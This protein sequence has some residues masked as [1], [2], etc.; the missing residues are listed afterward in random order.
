MAS[1]GTGGGFRALGGALVLVSVL[2]GLGLLVSRLKLGA[3]GAEGQVLSE[4]HALAREGLAIPVEGSEVPLIGGKVR[5]GVTTV[6]VEE[7]GERAIAVALLDFT[8]RLGSTEVSSLGY[9]RV[10]FVRR[11]GG[12]EPEQGPAPRL[13]ASVAALEA[14]RRA[15]EAGDVAALT[16]MQGADG[17]PPSAVPEMQQLLGL[18]RRRYEARSW[19]LRSERHE[20]LVAEHFRLTGD[21]R[22]APVDR[23][24]LR[25]L[26]LV[27]E[28]GKLTFSPRVM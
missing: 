2:V 21:A 14:R 3:G 8:G 23:L 20:V 4:L 1:P 19:I 13:A 22:E 16:A 17:P 27:P 10:P 12:W 18:Q 24:G 11:R 7:G 6:L 9:E 28:N 26:R 25:N 5:L 15:V